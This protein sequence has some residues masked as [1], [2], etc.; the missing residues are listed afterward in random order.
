MDM[1]TK[2]LLTVAASLLFAG[3][4]QNEITEI[5]PD[6]NPAVGFSVYSGVQT[7]GT[8]IK[9]EHLKPGFGV[10]AYHTGADAWSTAGS[11]ATPN[12]M[13]NQ[14]VESANGSL[15][16]YTPVKYW[17]KD[18]EKVT[19]F[20]Y[21]PYSTISGSGVTVLANTVAGAPKLTFAIES[22][23][24]ATK[25]I[26]FVVAKNDASATQ[27]RTHANSAS[28]VT[29]TFQHVLSRLTFEAKPS[30]ELS[31]TT[32][33]KGTT[34]VMVKSAKIL[35]ASSSKFYKSGVFDCA[36][37]TWGTKTQ[38]TADYDITKVLALTDEKSI[39]TAAEDQT[40]NKYDAV[41]LTSNA[42]PVSLFSTDASNIKQYLFLIP[43]TAKAGAG[44]TSAGDVTI[45]FQYDIVTVDT[46]VAKR[47]TITHHTTDA[48]LPAGALKQGTAYKYTVEF[49]INEIKILTPTVD[50]WGAD[51]TG[52][53]TA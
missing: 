3:C 24:D 30:V 51:S 5:S 18:G 12:F 41:K 32:S 44:T 48:K 40:S 11:T 23:G 50:S 43:E 14:K 45:Q 35:Q 4:S 19:F 10:F 31:A 2:N 20:A 34:Y 6:A 47:Y 28:G 53:I 46:A 29:F 1:K 49:G 21:G 26:D 7:K 27:D 15:W 22:T 16:T 13:Y 52:N 42:T 37:A 17:P 38:A 9:V 8:E 36:N 25:M 39:V 33:T